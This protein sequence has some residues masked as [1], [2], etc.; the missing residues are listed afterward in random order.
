VGDTAVE[1]LEVGP[2]HTK[3]DV[4][5]H[6]PSARVAFTGDILFIGSH[7]IAWEGPIGNWIA[8]CDRLLAL[9]VDVIVP[10]H[11]P[12]TDKEGVRQT[13]AYWEEL[14]RVTR[15]GVASGAASEDIARELL[16]TL[17][18][19]WT[20]AHRLV[21]NVDTIRREIVGDVSPRE[22]L[23]MFAKM[24]E[25]ERTRRREPRLR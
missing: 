10:G 23:G 19:D 5:V 22:P 24:A 25:V 16:R 21:V 6:V 11:G 13:K 14:T 20:E 2:A 1:L 4:V 15:E 9:P 12:V 3:G 18:V 7:P 17:S 8:A